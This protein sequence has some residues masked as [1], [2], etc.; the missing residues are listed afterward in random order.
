LRHAFAVHRLLKWYR[1][2]EDVQ[3]K[4]ILLTTYL[5]HACIQYTQFYLTITGLILAEA[6]ERF[7]AA[8]ERQLPLKPDG[9]SIR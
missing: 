7:S 3:N 4:L 1:D 2:G 9:G 8:M 5:G 6:N